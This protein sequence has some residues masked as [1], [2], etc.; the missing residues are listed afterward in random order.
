MSKGTEE[1]STFLLDQAHPFGLNL[2]H[3]GK[4]VAGVKRLGIELG[5]GVFLQSSIKHEIMG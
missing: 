4:R 1:Q 3:K 2:E 5:I